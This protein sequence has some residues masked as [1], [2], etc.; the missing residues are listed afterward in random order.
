VGSIVVGTGTPV[1]SVGESSL[2][3]WNTGVYTTFVQHD[4]K[5]ETPIEVLSHAISD[6]T[7]SIE[8]LSERI[9]TLEQKLELLASPAVD[10]RSIPDEE[11]RKEIKQLFETMH[12]E[13][14]FPSEIAAELHLDY[15]L[16]VRL[17]TDLEN[18]GS[19]KPAS[20]QADAR[21]QRR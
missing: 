16:V 12:G 14:I 5:V 6:L 10:V 1:R 20:R 7:A 19:I 11:A 4:I 18:E 2:T 8:R 9:A 15:E 17:L 13:V 21:N 3:L